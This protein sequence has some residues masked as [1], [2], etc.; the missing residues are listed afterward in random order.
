MFKPEL[1]DMTD[2]EPGYSSRSAH[3]AL[4]ASFFIPYNKFRCEVITLT[5]LRID[6]HMLIGLNLI[7]VYTVIA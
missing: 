7:L 5:A 1:N 3:F 6:A 4:R 2:D